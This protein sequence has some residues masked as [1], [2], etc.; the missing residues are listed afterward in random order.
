MTIKSSFRE[1]QKF[2]ILL[3]RPARLLNSETFV[4]LICQVLFEGFRSALVNQ[5]FHLSCETRLSRASSI[6]ATASSRLT[7]GYS[8][9]N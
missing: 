9:R 7:L 6:A 2:A 4:A 3:S 5:N 1:A 8:S